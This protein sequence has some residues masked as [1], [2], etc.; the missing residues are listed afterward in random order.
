MYLPPTFIMYLRGLVL[1][2]LLLSSIAHRRLRVNRFHHYAQLQNSTLTEAFEVSAEARE[3]WFPAARP[4][5]WQRFGPHSATIKPQGAV[6]RA[7]QP[8]VVAQ[9][10]TK[11]GST[12]CNQVRQPVILDQ[13]RNEGVATKGGRTQR[14]ARLYACASIGSANVL[15][16]V[17]NFRAVSPALPGLFRS[18]SLEGMTE[19]DA[20]FLLDCAKIRTIIDL[21][22][23]DEIDKAAEDSTHT[24]A[25]FRA[26]Y[27]DGAPVGAGRL[28]SEGSG[29]LRRIHVPLFEDVDGFFE[30]VEKQLNP[31]Q[32][33][34]ALMYKTLKAEQYVKLLYN[35]VARGKQHLLYSAMLRSNPAVWGRALALAADRRGGA[36]LIQSAKGKDRTGVLSALL[37]H[38][39]GED[40]PAIAEAYAASD[41]LLSEGAAA[42]ND[43]EDNAG[44]AESATEN[45]RVEW[46]ALSGSPREAILDTFKWIRGEYG[47]IDLF[48]ESIGCGEEWRVILL[49]GLQS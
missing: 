31:V 5:T 46:S 27:D 11:G 3:N 34:Q 41:A 28:A 19:H 29:F 9:V 42:L 39:A 49:Q 4:S 25:L 43:I 2:I 20:A 21:R 30:E 23:Q 22:S 36:V 13:V 7:L 8:R 26:A 45:A 14:V 38:A 1:S 24:A 10:A 18:A 48:L 47:A 32:K 44:R 16:G 40:L 12:G 35:E 6:T 37:Q 17:R 15:Q 33:A